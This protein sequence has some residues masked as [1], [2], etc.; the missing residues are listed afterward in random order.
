ML[1][2]RRAKRDAFLAKIGARPV[3]MGILNLTPDC[4][5][6]AAGSSPRMP[7]FSTRGRW[8]PPA[9]TS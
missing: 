5:P 3:V 4:F 9:A 8:R 2:D 6:M 7:R 1:A